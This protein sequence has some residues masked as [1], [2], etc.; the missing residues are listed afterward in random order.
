VSSN[1]L[2]N[3]HGVLGAGGCFESLISDEIWLENM[4]ISERASSL[5]KP[6]LLG[7]VKPNPNIKEYE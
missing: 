1:Q 4:F 2:D 7:R 6:V 3:A 5:Y